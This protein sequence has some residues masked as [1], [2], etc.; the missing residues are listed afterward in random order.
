MLLGR[1][2]M[3]SFLSF[4]QSHRTNSSN[5]DGRYRSPLLERS[6]PDRFTRLIVDGIS[7]KH[8]SGR[9]QWLRSKS[10]EEKNQD[11]IWQRR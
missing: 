2:V 7:L 5:P 4:S 11:Q 3:M 10:G 8:P 9:V 6:V 1:N